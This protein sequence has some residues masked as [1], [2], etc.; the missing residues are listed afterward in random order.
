MARL[1]AL[2]SQ[3]RSGP[4]ISYKYTA[5]QKRKTDSARDVHTVALTSP[6]DFSI[7]FLQSLLVSS[8]VHGTSVTRLPLHPPRRPP[9]PPPPLQALFSHQRRRRRRHHQLCLRPQ[10]RPRHMLRQHPVRPMH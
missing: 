9:P 4:S 3:T 7:I 8:Q 6:V 1:P 2:R 10:V 5:T